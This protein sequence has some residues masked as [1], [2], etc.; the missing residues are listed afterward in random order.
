MYTFLLGRP[1]CGKSVIYRTLAERV[2]REGLADDVVRIDDF[3]VLE[4]LLAEDVEHKRHVRKEGG[5]EVT[6]FSILDDVL[7]RI[8]QKLKEL[9]KPH[10]LIFVEFSRDRYTRALGNFDRE[11]LDRSL[12]I[13][14]YCPFE[15]CLKRNKRRFE[16]KRVAVDDHIVP[17][18]LMYKYYRYDDYEEL[19]LE[20]EDALQ[21]QAPTRLVVVKNDLEGLDKLVGELEKVV[22][23]LKE[24][25]N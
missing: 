6:D 13:Y 5:F 3:P 16:E 15:L 2:K 10:R 12:I 18:D 8:N 1:G 19:F 9:R 21:R 25:K 23:A 11:V 22:T 24:Y 7:K 4:E 17:T 14:I 20:S